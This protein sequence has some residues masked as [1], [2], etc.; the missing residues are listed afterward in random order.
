[1]TDATSSIPSSTYIIGG[2]SFAVLAGLTYY[3]LEGNKKTESSKPISQSELD[4]LVS[5]A[6]EEKKRRNQKKNKQS[7]PVQKEESKQVEEVPKKEEMKEQ[8]K[9]EEVKKE[10]K[11]RKKKGT[12]QQKKEPAKPLDLLANKITGDDEGEWEEVGK[13]NIDKKKS[14][15]DTQKKAKELYNSYLENF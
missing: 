4:E 8:P 14:Y 11:K 12:Q 15:Q 7:A 10:G 2:L 3:F 1:M 9:K 13:K 6:P 5:S